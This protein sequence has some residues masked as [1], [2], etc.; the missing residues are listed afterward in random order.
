MSLLLEMQVRVSERVVRAL[1]SLATTRDPLVDEVRR[2]GVLTEGKAREFAVRN[3]YDTGELA[4]SI[5]NEW[6]A[7]LEGGSVVVYSDL[8]YA[9]VMEH[10]RA[11]GSFPPLEPLELWIR[12]KGLEIPAY[13]LALHIFREGIDREGKE[14]FEPAREWAEEQMPEVQGRIAINRRVFGR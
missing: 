9:P 13:A 6:H 5:A 14:F 8:E 10:G 3:A 1:R 12:R 4:R 7:D 11:P 2:L